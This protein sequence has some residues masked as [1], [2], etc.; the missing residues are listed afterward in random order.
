MTLF[1]WLMLAATGDSSLLP[2]A[3]VF[4]SP[5]TGGRIAAMRIAN[6]E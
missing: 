2:L 5:L 1:G 3:N 4:V 6:F